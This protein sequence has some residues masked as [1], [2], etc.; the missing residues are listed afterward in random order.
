MLTKF[1]NRTPLV[2]DTPLSNFVQSSS[3][4][5][6]RKIYNMVIQQATQEQRRLI[7]LAHKKGSQESIT[8]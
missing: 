5:E 6:K 8:A 2:K 4:A 7:E 3:S 1:F